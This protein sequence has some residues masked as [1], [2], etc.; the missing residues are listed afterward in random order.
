VVGDLLA[1][2]EKSG[3]DSSVNGKTPPTLNGF[4]FAGSP[5]DVTP[6]G[7]AKMVVFLAHWCP[8]CNREIPVIE[9]WAAAGRVPQGLDII[10]ISTA[11]T[12]QRDNYPPSEW[13]QRMNWTSPV[14]ADSANGDAARAWGVGGFPT[15]VIVGTDGTVKMR[16]SGE[17]TLEEMDTFVRQALGV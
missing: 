3:A 2:Q 16:F 11:V 8:H 13:L 10:G 4:T 17:M 9:Q 15:I 7:T 5:I 12:N 1:P 14:M 6:G